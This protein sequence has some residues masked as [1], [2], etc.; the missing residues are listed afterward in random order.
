MAGKDWQEKEEPLN[1]LPA[2]AGGMVP[3]IF[4]RPRAVV[5]RSGKIRYY[6]T[7]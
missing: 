5:T 1:G 2:A 4:V 7:F 3:T 6:T